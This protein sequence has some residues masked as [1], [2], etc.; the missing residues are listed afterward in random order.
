MGRNGRVVV[1]GL[2]AMLVLAA[3]GGG[4][5]SSTT[6][7]TLTI[8]FV[9]KD[10]QVP[11]WIAMRNGATQEAQKKGVNLIFEAGKTSSDNA[12]QTADID[13]F[14]TRHV[15]AIVVAP[16]LSAG[17]VPAVTRATQAG[18]P[19]IAVDTNTD[20]PSAV[21]S[22]IA[23]DSVRA[24]LLQGQWAHAALAGKKPVIAAMHCELGS[25]VD[26][27]RWNGFMQGFGSDA[28]N[29]VV[30]SFETHGLYADTQTATENLLTAHRD[31]NV[32]W[33]CGDDGAQGAGKAVADAGL[34]GQVLITGM[35]GGCAAIQEVANGTFQADFMQFPVK[36]G[37]LGIDNAILLAQGKQVPTRID[38]GG[39][40]V[41]DMPQT[42]VPS[43]NTA[44]GFQ[45]CF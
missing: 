7:K 25:S 30:G 15:D 17:I 19:V 33:N 26:T 16:G 27:D 6:S 8:G 43:Q 42:G 4:S 39:S 23:T 44:W 11:F 40:L 24:G 5:S 20:P 35:D 41:T 2:M 22:F 38:T 29:N 36:V 18:I 9:V 34:K 37:I 1:A 45:N 12:G 31:V 21:K 10:F 28:A 13:D 14:I 32:I 3:C